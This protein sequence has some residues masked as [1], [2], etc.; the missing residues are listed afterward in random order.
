M[1]NKASGESE[2]MPGIRRG[3]TA[4]GSHTVQSLLGHGRMLLYPKCGG[5]PFECL[6]IGRDHN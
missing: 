5:Q 1:A 4:R 3:P 2:G 6:N